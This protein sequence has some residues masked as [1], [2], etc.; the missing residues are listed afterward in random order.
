MG[1]VVVALVSAVVGGIFWVILP[2][3]VE[4][5]KASSEAVDVRQTAYDVPEDA[6]FVAKDGDDQ[7]LGT[8]ENPLRTLSAAVAKAPAD[9]TIVM[10]AGE[11]REGVVDIARPLT[12]QPYPQD[13]VWL[14]G[15]TTLDIGGTASGTKIRGLGFDGASTTQTAV[16]LL[17][18]GVTLE[19]NV[20]VDFA[21]NAVR[22]SGS[23]A[24]V[25]NNTFHGNATQLALEASASVSARSDSYSR[26]GSDVQSN[27]FVGT[28]STRTLLD[29]GVSASGSADLLST[30]GGNRVQGAEA[31]RWCASVSP[32]SC[33]THESLGEFASATGLVFGTSAKPSGLSDS[34]TSSV[35][36]TDDSIPAID[37]ADPSTKPTDPDGT[38]SPA[39][40]SDP[41]EGPLQ[42]GTGTMNPSNPG[43]GTGTNPKGEDSP[44]PDKNDPKNNGNSGSSG[45]PGGNPSKVTP[46]SA[47]PSAPTPTASVP[48]APAVVDVTPS[49][50][51]VVPPVAAPPLAE[52]PRATSPALVAAPVL[53][54]APTPAVSVSDVA[55]PRPVQPLLPSTLGTPSLSLNTGSGSSTSAAAPTKAAPIPTPR[56]LK[57]LEYNALGQ[58]VTEKGAMGTDQFV[59]GIASDALVGG[60][61][62]AADAESPEVPLTE[63]ETTKPRHEARKAG[64]SKEGGGIGMMLPIGLGIAALLAAAGAFALRQES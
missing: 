41:A 10:R 3:V 53:P 17:A 30:V 2:G 11:Y 54:K 49:A 61:T 7:G 51:A 40:P 15:G 16:R 34:S 24:V 5:A 31:I 55:I 62:T 14:R 6:L 29:A 50:P 52:A 20:I 63:S 21:G 45:N 33:V 42:P 22:V 26:S 8:A 48:T 44:K 46:T 64:A 47:T 59:D 57:I 27:L 28:R 36:P 18:S 9:A 35:A 25:S 58:P 12:I 56:L 23:A 19:Q 38:T 39:D 32:E 1:R 37:V 4:N 43:K 13:A 60:G